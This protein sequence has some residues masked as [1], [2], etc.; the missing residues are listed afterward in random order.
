MCAVVLFGAP[1]VRRGSFLLPRRSSRLC[2]L[3]SRQINDLQCEGRI[4]LRESAGRGTWAQGVA[5]SSPVAPTTFLRN[6]HNHNQYGHLARPLSA[7]AVCRHSPQIAVFCI[8]LGPN[9]G[10]QK[11]QLSDANQGGCWKAAV[12]SGHTR[13]RAAMSGHFRSGPHPSFSN[14]R[15]H[16]FRSSID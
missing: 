16:G 4:R 3:N 7:R 5:G 11:S 14:W 2:A 8:G 10:P 1:F 9:V 6:L 12:K 13:R 15:S